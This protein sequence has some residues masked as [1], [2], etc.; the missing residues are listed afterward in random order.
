MTGLQKNDGTKDWFFGES[1]GEKEGIQ[2]TEKGGEN[3][4]R[5]TV[6]K[7]RQTNITQKHTK[8]SIKNINLK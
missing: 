1:K 5:G 4:K 2:Y 8:T 3:V 6:Q 7:T